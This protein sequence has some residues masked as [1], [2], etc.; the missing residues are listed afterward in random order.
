[1]KTTTQQ[2]AIELSKIITN[3]ELN[4]DIQKAIKQLSHYSTE[5]FINDAN[6]YLLAIEQGRMI[7]SIGSVSASGMSRNIKFLSCEKHSNEDRY[8]YYNFYCLFVAL[9]FRK[10][11]KDHYFNINGCGMDMIFHTNYTIVHDLF[12]LGFIDKAK[13]EVLAQMT[14]TTI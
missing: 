7:N 10:A 4:K 5:Q 2:T 12:R 1:M 6:R 3:I 8:Q 14:P 13:C 9:G 11:K